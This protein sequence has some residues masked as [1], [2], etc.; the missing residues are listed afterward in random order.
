MLKSVI[1]EK[2]DT[3]SLKS[4]NDIAKYLNS[5]Y[6]TVRYQYTKPN[7]KPIRGG[8][9]I[10]LLYNVIIGNMI[11]DAMLWLLEPVD[12]LKNIYGINLFFNR[13]NE[14]LLLEC[15]GRGF[16]TSELNRGYMNPHQSIIFQL[17]IEYG[18]Y[19]EWWKYAKFEFIA[20]SE[21]E[22]SKY[23]RLRNLHDL[24]LTA[25]AEL[26]DSAYK[27]LP[28]YLI[29]KL[30]GYAMKL[31]DNLIDEEDFVV[32]CSI[33]ENNKIV[34]WDIATPKGKIETFLGWQ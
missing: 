5:D 6:C 4:I 7:V 1:I 13:H 24:K 29:E 15:V 32:S 8:N 30:M 23:I 21:Y 25:D 34:F 27:P 31:Y 3:F 20:N 16:D 22:K 18:W 12:R 9:K 10:A 33:L 11:P 14:S 2:N 17:P 26:F 19:S 28:L